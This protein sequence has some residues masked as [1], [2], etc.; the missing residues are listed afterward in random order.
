MC[1]AG[2]RRQV[3]LGKAQYIPN[4]A[5]LGGLHQPVAS[6]LAM[7][8]LYEGA[9]GQHRHYTLQVFKRNILPVCNILHRNIAAVPVFCQIYK[10]S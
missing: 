1:Q 6:P 9:L 8:A 3:P 2:Y 4:P 7:D 10:H 5:I